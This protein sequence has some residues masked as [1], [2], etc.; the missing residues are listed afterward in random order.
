MY[1]LI[2]ISHGGGPGAYIPDMRAMLLP[3]L[4]NVLADLCQSAK[5][6]KRSDD[7]WSLE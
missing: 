6:P 5:E 2:L 7:F 1:R 4:E 3:H